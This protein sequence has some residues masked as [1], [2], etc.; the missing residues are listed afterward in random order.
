VRPPAPPAEPLPRPETPVPEAGAPFKE[1]PLLRHSVQVGAFSRVSN[2]VRLS[3]LLQKRGLDAFYFMHE[4]G[5]FKVRF[6]DFPTKE[7]ALSKVEELRAAGIVDEVYIVG[8]E[9]YASAQVRLRGKLYLRDQLVRTARTFLGI[10]Y[11]WGGS[12]VEEGFD[13]SGLSM[14]V[15]QL[16]GLNLPRHSRTQWDYG[17]SVS[18][19]ALEK[20]DLVFFAMASKKRIDHVG[21]YVGDGRFIHAPSRGKDIRISSLHSRYF[22]ER[23][24]GARTYI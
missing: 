12:S 5:L 20:G 7:A 23:Y 8:P 4:S 21:I 22:T 9:D 3:E 17:R 13:C 10:P 6:G 24:V 1:L 11:K 14:A 18:A 19:T 2:A 15:Y 16:N